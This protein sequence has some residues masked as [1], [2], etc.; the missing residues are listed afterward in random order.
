MKLSIYEFAFLLLLVG[1][2]LGV[3]LVVIDRIEGHFFKDS[4]RE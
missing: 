3:W 2:A 1:G 4:S